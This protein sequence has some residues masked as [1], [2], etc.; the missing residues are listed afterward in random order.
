MS[1]IIIA[2]VIKKSAN[3]TISVEI[4]RTVTHKKYHKQVIK[5]NKLLVNDPENITIVGNKIVISSVKPISKRKQYQ[6]VSIIK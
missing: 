6:V 3:Q 4:E 1:K 5:K 2:K